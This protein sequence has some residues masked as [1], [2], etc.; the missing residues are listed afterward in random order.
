MAYGGC[1]ISSKFIEQAIRMSICIC[2]VFNTNAYLYSLYSIVLPF[3]QYKH[4]NK[5]E[6]LSGVCWATIPSS[7]PNG[8]TK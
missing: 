3:I 5:T 2:I 1:Q 6:V 7:H 4:M 8:N